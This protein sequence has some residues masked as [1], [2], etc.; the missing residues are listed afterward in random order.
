MKWTRR[1]AT[2][3]GRQSGQ[4][5]GDV[6]QAQGK[7][8]PAISLPWIGADS[9]VQIVPSAAAFSVILRFDAASEAAN[10]HVQRTGHQGITP[11]KISN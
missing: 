5:F 11:N 3:M 7:E 10:T 8:Y 6:R 4:G 2:G 1:T 9:G